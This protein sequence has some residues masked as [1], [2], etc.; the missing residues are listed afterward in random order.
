MRKRGSVFLA[1]MLCLAGCGANA[2]MS[3]AAIDR[4]TADGVAPGLIYAIDVPGFTLAEQSVG[5]V[6]EN[7]FGG[8]YFDERGGRI[9]MRVD[10]GPYDDDRCAKTPMMAGTAPATCA[11]DDA[12]WY[13]TAG[14]D[15]E[16]VG[17]RGDHSIRLIT[18]TA[19]VTRQTLKTALAKARPAIGDGRTPSPASPRP[20][21]TRGDLPTNGDGAPLNPTGPGG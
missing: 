7:G 1:G 15:Q 20:A 13:R 9:E 8:V 17:V 12:G 10:R 14:D 16:Y 4:A 5:V 2:A 18:K 6:N 11:R 19:T 3:Q 21:V